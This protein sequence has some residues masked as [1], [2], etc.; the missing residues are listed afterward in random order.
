[1]NV[2]K[3]FAYCFGKLVSL[4][5][6]A[7]RGSTT[8]LSV[9]CV[10]IS[11]N[12]VAQNVCDAYYEE[13]LGSPRS[14]IPRY[15][16]DGTIKGFFVYDETAFRRDTPS[17]HAAAR[18][19]AEAGVREI[20]SSFVLTNM[21]AQALFNDS[22][23]QEV[24]STSASEEVLIN[25]LSEQITTIKENTS[26]AISGFVKADECV[27][28]ERMVVSVMYAWKPEFSQ[29]GA[30]A[31]REMQRA[32]DG[33]SGTFSRQNQEQTDSS[34]VKSESRRTKSDIDF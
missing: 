20:W 13:A 23:R 6:R 27:D 15:N 4:S 21:D 14:V 1:M 7:M 18:R 17:L 24:T 30:D 26:G 12:S 29:M 5:G 11:Q 33:D 34:A 2:K 19:R 10:L 32:L 3:S 31:S 28:R 9:I 8:L 22:I 16:D 25:E